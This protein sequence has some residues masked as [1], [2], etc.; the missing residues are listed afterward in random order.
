VVEAL[1]V[2]RIGGDETIGRGLTH[3]VWLGH[4]QEES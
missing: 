2:M 3:L 1:K 4:T